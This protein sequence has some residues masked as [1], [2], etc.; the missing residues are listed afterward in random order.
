MLVASA[1][2]SLLAPIAAQASDVI[3][4]EEMNSYSRSKKKENSKI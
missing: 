1:T 4:I 3:N 2:L